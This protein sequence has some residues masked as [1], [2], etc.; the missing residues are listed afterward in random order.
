M[1]IRERLRNWLKN[2]RIMLPAGLVLVLLLGIGWVG[3][4]GT[5]ASG[6]LGAAAKLFVQLKQQVETGDAGSAKRT[7]VSLR[8][9]TDAARAETAGP[10]WSLGTV[11]PKVGDDLAAA[12]TI[13]E[14]LDVLADDSLPPLLE[15]ASG[16]E[17]AVLAPEIGRAHV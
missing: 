1:R 6:H 14:E 4:R 17:A 10:A 11:L 15:A 16:L 8:R 13:A 7:L 12:R 5:Q 9:E 3:Y 2:W